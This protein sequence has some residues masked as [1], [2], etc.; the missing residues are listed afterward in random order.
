MYG[1]VE[2]MCILLNTA[3]HFP[4]KLLTFI[5]RQVFAIII[6]IRSMRE[7]RRSGSKAISE[8]G[9]LYFGFDKF[10]LSTFHLS[11][12]TMEIF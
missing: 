5:C 10:I 2:R 11:S 7:S 12:P 6:C 3:Y 8:N 1:A 9:R 4:P